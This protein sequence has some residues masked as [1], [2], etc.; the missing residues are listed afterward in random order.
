MGTCSAVPRPGHRNVSGMLLQFSCGSL[1]LIDCGEATQHQLMRSSVRFGSI[2]NILFTHLH[3]DHCYGIFGLLHTLNSGG[4]TAP[5]NVF[6]P[7]GIDELVGT[8]LRLTGGWNGFPINVTEFEP[9]NHR[10]FNLKSSSGTH[11]GSVD[12]FPMVHRVPAFGYVFREPEPE[13]VLDG[14]KA[15]SLGVQGRDL[16]VLK[17]GSDVSLPNGVR[18]RAWDVTS[19]GKPARTIGIMQDTS[20]ASAAV[21]VMPNCDL[22]IHEATYDKEL[23]EKAILYG[24]STSVM[25]ADIAARVNAK[26]LV[27]TH[28]SSRY[29]EK[30]ENEILRTEASE[31]LASRNVNTNVV[32]AEDFMCLSGDDFS[33]ITSVLKKD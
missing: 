6:G 29:G 10:N 23:E 24:H 5:V 18:V 8:V 14:N 9:E 33:T 28:F 21:P 27:L 15:R 13:L 3:G 16:G 2:D 19:P 30:G 22:L 1:A 12:A 20:N 11:L 17:S 31:Y 32:L 7:R 25:A 4:R 26:N